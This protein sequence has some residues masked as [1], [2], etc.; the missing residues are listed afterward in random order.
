MF[1]LEKASNKQDQYTRRNNLEILGIPVDVKDEQLEQKVIDI[2][3]H[4]NINISKPDIEGCHQLGKSNAI[5]RFVSRKVWKDAL[6]KKFEVNRLI[7]NSMFGFKRENKLFTC[8]NLTPYNQCLAWMCRDLKRAKKI[9]NFWSN[10]GIIKFR[11]TM[12][13]RSTSVDH[14][15]EPYIQT[16]FS[17]RGIEHHEW[18]LFVLL[19]IKIK[20]IIRMS[21]YKYLTHA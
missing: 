19:N 20:F 16:L 6:E 13:E 3:S 1:D 4:L 14:E 10:K 11:R 12:N 15:S 8:E 17:K 2:F 9:H 7:N 18:I 5:V 21:L